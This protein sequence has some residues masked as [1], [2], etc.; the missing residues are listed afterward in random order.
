MQPD[1]PSY[2][3]RTH[4]C[5]QHGICGAVSVEEYATGVIKRHEKTQVKKENDRTR[6]TYTQVRFL[7]VLL[8]LVDAMGAWGL[9]TTR[10]LIDE[11]TATTPRPTE[12]ERGPRLHHVQAQGGAG[13]DRAAGHH[14]HGARDL[15]RGGRR[16]HRAPGLARERRADRQRHPGR[17]REVRFCRSVGRG[18]AWS[19]LH[20]RTWV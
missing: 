16:R 20:V 15:L 13:R 12:C 17:L 6:L 3:T 8:C 7:G 4:V 2:C 9:Q 14:L 11:R 5:V 10:R 19:F 1:I 18:H